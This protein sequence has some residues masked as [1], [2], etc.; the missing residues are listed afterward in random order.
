MGVYIPQTLQRLNNWV[1]WRLENGKKK[2]YS[3]RYDGLASVAKPYQW[4]DYESARAKLQHTD[5][6]GL[7]F[8]FSAGCGLVFI[9]LDNCIDSSG[10]PNGFASEI[11]DLFSS[12]Y[13]EYSQSGRGLHIVC[14][15]VIP[16]AYKGEQIEL[17]SSGRYMAFTGD[18]YTANEPAEAQ[19]ALDTLCK[20]FNIRAQD[21]RQRIDEKPVTASDKAIID[22]AQRGKHG[23]QFCRLWAGDWS[24]YETR[25]QADMRLIALLWYYSGNVEQVERLFQASGLADREKAQRVDYVRRTIETAARNA[26]GAAA[27]SGGSVTDRGG[28]YAASTPKQQQKKHRQRGYWNK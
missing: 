5:Y 15:G 9:D 25:S 16:A 7:G 17:Y 4:S 12:S 2:P 28:K 20:R 19:T 8:V 26:S 22:K 24:K 14:K 1:L 27:G 6:N 21:Q 11:I 3:A 10:E 18:C 13:I 23:A